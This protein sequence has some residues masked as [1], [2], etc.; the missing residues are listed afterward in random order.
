MAEDKLVRAAT[1]M[2]NKLDRLLSNCEEMASLLLDSTKMV[3][4]SPGL[5]NLELYLTSLI[6]RIERLHEQV[7]SVEFNLTGS[8]LETSTQSASLEAPL[9]QKLDAVVLKWFLERIKDP[10]ESC[11][12]RVQHVTE[13]LQLEHSSRSN[14]QAKGLPATVLAHAQNLNAGLEALVSNQSVVNNVKSSLAARSEQRNA[15]LADE[16]EDQK[17]LTELELLANSSLLSP[18]AYEQITTKF[19]EI[20]GSKFREHKKSEARGYRSKRNFGSCKPSISFSGPLHVESTNSGF[21]N[22]KNNTERVIGSNSWSTPSC[23]LSHSSPELR[24]IDHKEPV[25]KRTEFQPN[26][27]SSLIV[28]QEIDTCK[29]FP[30]C[31]VSVHIS[32]QNKCSGKAVHAIDVALCK[33]L[34]PIE[35]KGRSGKSRRFSL[36]LSKEKVENEQVHTIDKSSFVLSGFPVEPNTSWQG[37]LVYMLPEKITPCAGSETYRLDLILHLNKKASKSD[38]RMGI[39]VQIPTL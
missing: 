9:M 24:S 7:K 38:L 5:E 33:K 31:R 10:I 2:L 25:S 34:E 11:E 6:S 39:P 20:G 1:F 32:I 8:E 36:K 29:L 12:A 4:L 35:K 30:G 13:H 17:D 26:S 3:L 19:A 18:Q 23:T 21:D 22:V 28:T 27:K 16:I 15:L 37:N 14:I